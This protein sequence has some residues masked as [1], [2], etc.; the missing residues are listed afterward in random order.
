MKNGIITVELGE[1]KR[2]LRFGMFAFEIMLEMFANLKENEH[3]KRTAVAIY[4]GLLN[5]LEIT[6]AEVNFRFQDVYDWTDQLFCSKEGS[7]IIKDIDKCIEESNMFVSH[8][9]P[10]VDAVG[11]KK[12]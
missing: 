11:K 8:L 2:T 9:K 4:A 7:L 12:E 1:E 10:L 3:V 5:H 6:D